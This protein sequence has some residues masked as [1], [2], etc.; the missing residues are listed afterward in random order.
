MYPLFS[1]LNTF[2][3]IWIPQFKLDGKLGV[4]CIIVDNAY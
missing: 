2:K 4:N 3:I 1:I